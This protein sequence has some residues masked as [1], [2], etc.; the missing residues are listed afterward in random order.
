[1]ER[2]FGWIARFRRLAHAYER[3]A[4][5]LAG[6]QVVAFTCLMLDKLVTMLGTNS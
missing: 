1:M 3:L 5:S 2:S 4:E 6:L